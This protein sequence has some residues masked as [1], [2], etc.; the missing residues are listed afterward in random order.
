MRVPW[1]L[2]MIAL[3]VVA[4]TLSSETAYLFLGARSAIPEGLAGRILGTLD[5]ALILVLTYYF[6]TSI[7]H[8]RGPQ[9]AAD[10]PPPPPPDTKGPA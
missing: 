4:T 6:A 8:A 3:I 9:R 5:S 2:H 1:Q 7:A 10:T